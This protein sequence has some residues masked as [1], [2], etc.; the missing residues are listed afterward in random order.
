[1]QAAEETLR[2]GNVLRDIIFFL[3]CVFWNGIGFDFSVGRGVSLSPLL[4]AVSSSM[5][6][7]LTLDL[8]IILF[9]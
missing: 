2:G 8:R 6:D 5:D 1:M 4:I 3:M 9:F 7:L